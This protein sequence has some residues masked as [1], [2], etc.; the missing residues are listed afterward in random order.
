MALWEK[1]KL[2]KNRH[3]CVY[4]GHKIVLNAAECRMLLGSDCL[5]S[6]SE[7]ELLREHL[8]ALAGI[9]T[10]EFIKN[11]ESSRLL[12]GFNGRSS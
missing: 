2:Y 3:F 4:I 5:L 6:D 11:H 12:S 7:L 10:D 8:Y 1:G 9:L